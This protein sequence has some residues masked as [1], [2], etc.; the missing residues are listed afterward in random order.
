MKNMQYTEL[1]QCKKCYKG[2]IQSIR[3]LVGRVGVVGIASTLGAG[4]SGDRIPMRARFPA[5]V[6]IGPGAHPVSC[7]MGAMSLSRE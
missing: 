7:K 6:Q 5:S 2:L 1:Q 4:R 3:M